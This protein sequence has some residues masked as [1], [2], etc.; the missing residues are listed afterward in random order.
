MKIIADVGGTRGRWVIV[1]K[2]IIKTIETDGFNPYSNSLSSL[3]SILDQILLSI[4]SY[5]IDEIIYY[6]AGINNQETTKNVKGLL[7]KHFKNVKIDV[8]SDLL[9][10]CRALC[11][12]KKGI[13]SILGT[14][15]N[16]CY[17]DGN[18]INMQ[19]K[20]LGYLLGDEGSGYSLGRVFLKKYLR[21]ELNDRISKKFNDKYAIRNDNYKILYEKNSNKI[22]ANFAGFINENK[23]DKIIN[24]LIFDHFEYYFKE[25]VIKYNKKELYLTGSIAHYFEKEIR[26]VSKKFNIDVMQIEKDPIDH[27]VNYHVK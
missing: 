5:K 8:F 12:Q 1:D 16:S 23:D 20:S 25:V 11:N 10:S 19:I 4:K 21:G 9:G 22:I 17:Y 3:N 24:D 26:E 13:V 7:K 6:G 18:E 27:L 14:G 2:K 15:S